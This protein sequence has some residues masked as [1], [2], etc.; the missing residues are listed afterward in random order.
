MNAPRRAPR[1]LAASIASVAALL[2]L[3]AAATSGGAPPSAGSSAGVTTVPVQVLP[4]GLGPL[5]GLRLRLVPPGTA[6]LG[7]RTGADAAAR[8]HAVRFTKPFWIGECEVTQTQWRAVMGTN[9]SMVR[10]DDLPVERVSYDDCQDFLRRLRSLDGRAYRL[11]NADEWEY[12]RRAGSSALA[13]ADEERL[14][15]AAAATYVHRRMLAPA[16]ACPANAWGLRG[17][18]GNAWEWVA[19]ADP[20]LPQRRLMCGGSCNMVPRWCRPEARLSYPTDFIHERRGLRLAL[21]GHAAL[22]VTVA[23]DLH[24]L[25]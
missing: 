7:D 11:P 4:L 20:E 3:S 1:L 2:V 15:A 23:A 25:L 12:A 24:S 18:D 6:I 10:G 9:P 16:A 21:D 13:V 19:S 8:P 5:A 17:M 22:P 14:F